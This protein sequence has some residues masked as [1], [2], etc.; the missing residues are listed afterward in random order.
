MVTGQIEKTGWMR[1]A[2]TD[3]DV[4][5]AMR[6]VPRHAFVPS[7]LASRAYD[8]TPL[9][10]GH[11]QTISQP[12]IV[13]YM[14]EL[15]ELT[16]KSKVLEI[17]T[18]SGYQAAVLAQLTPHVYTI[19]ILQP[20]AER[21]ARTLEEQGYTGVDL[22]HADGYYGW[23]EAAPFDAI[24]VTCAAGHLPPPL[25]DQIKPGGRIVIPIGGTYSVQR[26]VVIEKT[27]D[28]KRKTD[29]VMGVRF[30]PMTGQAMEE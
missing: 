30:V 9:P 16:P 26:L 21:A 14:T 12:Y 8:D 19:E 2:V 3:R 11:G 25:W 7:K 27:Q 28:G 10:I 4:L 6:I 13:A 1:D 17:G 5:R 23:P 24:I 18:G 22:R 15:L 20:L 29:S